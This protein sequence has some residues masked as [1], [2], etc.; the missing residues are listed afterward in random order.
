MNEAELD[1]IELDAT[2]AG[3]GADTQN[4]PSMGVDALQLPVPYVV[5]AADA[6]AQAARQGGAQQ[7]PLLTY[8]QAAPLDGILRKMQG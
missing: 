7:Q 8:L 4:N 6:A 1:A 2:V 3:A 5:A